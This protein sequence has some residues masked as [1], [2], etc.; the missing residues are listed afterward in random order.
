L[1]SLKLRANNNYLRAAITQP[2]VDVSNYEIKP[3]L[4]KLVQENQ[5]GGSSSEDVVCTLVLSL[6]YVR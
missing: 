2:T 5:F 4:L 1:G 6:K 3:N